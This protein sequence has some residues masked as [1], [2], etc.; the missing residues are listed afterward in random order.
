MQRWPDNALVQAAWAAQRYGAGA[1]PEALTALRK[2]VAL[3][4]DNAAYANNLASLELA[5]GCPAAGLAV[6]DRID[7]SRASPANAAA[8]RATRAEIEA[9]PAVACPDDPV[10]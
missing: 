9:S 3:A 4:P 2:A 1:L 7:A 10:R 6:L 8:L 5:R